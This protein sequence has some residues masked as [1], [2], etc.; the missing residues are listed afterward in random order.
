MAL[1]GVDFTQFGG[2]IICCCFHDSV[3]ISIISD[4]GR[5]YFLAS[6]VITLSPMPL[7]EL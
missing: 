7:N 4:V 1:F 6:T 3:W 2:M 5:H